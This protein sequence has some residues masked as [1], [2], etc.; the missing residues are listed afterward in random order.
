M[1]ID[2]PLADGRLLEGV[3]DLVFT[4]LD[5][6]VVVDFKTDTTAS[7]RYERQL[8]WYVYALAKLTGRNATGHLLHV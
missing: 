6:W 3:I 1:P 4:E 8:Q 2:L 7:A 5:S